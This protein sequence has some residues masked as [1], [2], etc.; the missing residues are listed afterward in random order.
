MQS[1]V[2]TFFH[3]KPGDV[4]EFFF[5][6]YFSPLVHPRQKEKFINRKNS[7]SPARKICVVGWV[8]K[9]WGG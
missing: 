9:P 6:K 3:G 7:G 4:P 2:L 1:L 8:P 5:L